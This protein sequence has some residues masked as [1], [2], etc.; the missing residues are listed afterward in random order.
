MNEI[1]ELIK[2]SN[3]VAILWRGGE[4]ICGLGI[5]AVGMRVTTWQLQ[6]NYFL[7]LIGWL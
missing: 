3:F 7:I 5:R 1:S 6:E 4:W 2:Y